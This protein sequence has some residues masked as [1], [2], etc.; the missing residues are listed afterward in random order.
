MTP[1]RILVVDD[2]EVNLYVLRSLLEG[3]GYTVDTARHGAEALVKA[4]AAPP[5]LAISD[6]LMPVMDG[7]TLLRHWKAD[8]R[9]R[10]IPF[11]V[12]TATYTEPADEKLALDLGADAFILKPA[13]PDTFV[14]R[15]REVLA[16]EQR[17]ELPP[18]HAPAAEERIVLREYNE[19]LVHKLEDKALQLEQANSALMQDIAARERAEAA[20]RESEQH[21]RLLFDNSPIGLALCRMDG[22]LVYVN[23]AY[24]RILGRTPEETLHLSYWD[25]TPPQ[26]A[27]Q[28][29]AQLR[30][31]R[32]TGR[33]GPYEKEYI[34]R[35]GHRVPV[36]LSGLLITQAGEQ[37]IWSS[38]EEITE[39][40]RAE[41]AL[42]RSNRALRILTECNEIMMRAGT[43]AELCQGVC[44]LLVGPGRFVMA[45]V[46]FAQEDD[47]KS[48]RP[49]A[50]SGFEAGYLDSL[51]ITWADQERG[52]G[53]SG[54]AIRTGA[55]SIARDIATDPAYGPWRAAAIQR[56]YASS[57]S[58]P[59][60]VSNQVVGA[61]SIYSAE[62]NAFDGGE[63]ELMT[64]LADDLAFGIQALRTRAKRQQAEEET[65]LR[66][67]ELAILSDLVGATA[68][69]LD[70]PT[71]LDRALR[72]ALELT[73]LEGGTLC[74]VHRDG[75]HLDLAAQI[76]TS[77]E[78]IRDLTT[79]AVRIGD[80]LCGECAR[81]CRPL[82]LWDNASG[83]EYATRESAR[84]EGI[85]FH[86]A[87][88]LPVHD[89]TIGVLCIFSRGDLQPSERR[90]KLVESLCGPVALAIENAR[91]FE[92]T[93]RELAARRQA[94]ALLSGQKRVL[95]LI[96]TGASLPESLTALVQLIESHA[97]GMLGSV[98]LLDDDGVHVR[99]G[100]APSL[101][102][103]FVAAVDGQPIGPV[104][105][106]CGT[107]AFRKEAVFVEDIATDPLWA[108][109]KAAALPHGLRACW[110]TP[111]LDASGIVL[112]TFAMYYREP[113]LPQPEHLR[114]IDIATQTAAIAI[115]RHR[116]EA[117]LRAKTGE[118]DRYFNNSLDLLCIADI[119]GYFRR[120]NPEWERTL[121]YPLAELVGRRFL[122][123]V[124]PDDMAATLA[125][126]SALSSQQHVLDFVNRYRHK[127]GTYRWIE[128]RA[129]AEDSRLYAVARDITER[130]R[131]EEASRA[132]QQRLRELIDGLGPSMLVGLLAPDGTVIEANRPALAA[133]A[134]KPEDVLGKPVDET[135]WWAYSPDIQRQVREA[136]GRA[137]RGEASRYDVDVRVAD[138]QFIT[139]DFS[140]EP[141]RDNTGT[142]VYVVASASVITERRRAEA[143]LRES[144]AKFRAIIE[145]SP[146]AMT[147][148]DEHGNIVFLNRKFVETFGYT[149][150]DIPTLAEWRLRA[151]PDPAYREQVAASWHASVG[152]AHS[153]RVER[154]PLEYRVT[155]KDGTV[156]DIRFSMAPIGTSSLVVLYDITELKQA[157]E[158]LR[159]AEAKFAGAFYGSPAAFSITRI[160]DGMFL[161]V[162]ESFLRTFGYRRDEVVG[163]R[164]T[165][166]GIITPEQRARLIQ[167]QLESGGLTNEELTAV[168][169]SGA[170]VQLLF[171]SRPLEVDGEACHVTTLID[172]TDRKLAEE[173]LL[174]ANAQLQSLSGR[175]LEIQEAER[176]TLA[177][178][179]HDELGQ[180]LSAI[181]IN[182]QTLQRF[183]VPEP[184]QL[185]ACAAMVDEA[186]Q[187]TRS[188]SLNLRPPLLDDLGL[189][190]ALRW[191]ADQVG[192]R[193]GL[194]V[195]V[196]SD[197]PMGRLAAPVETACFR[198][199]QEALSNAVRHAQ[200][201]QAVI[202]IVHTTDRLQV[203]VRDDGVGFDEAA[204]RR[205][206]REGG[207]MGLMSMEERATL[208]GGGVAWNSAPGSGTEVRFW[209]PLSASLARDTE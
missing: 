183:P 73:G 45:W 128:W 190:P 119:D 116:A 197:R 109:Y 99:H 181:K 85:R 100:A 83:S 102:A 96:A 105:G 177:R 7:Y 71:V 56:G 8:E 180:S 123:F 127:D 89:R 142:V 133:A 32:E 155:C 95:E 204:A 3:H 16:Q 134:L 130:R 60:K 4:R 132:S 17:G 82:V 115:S 67:R 11:V 206:A 141:V 175:L 46:G 90:L 68:T 193:A 61:L 136:V 64:E 35:D 139:L 49:M 209:V 106:S 120:L 53:P 126:M 1:K 205:R 65:A 179:L 57:I 107:A 110:S 176:R 137:A 189:L 202:S 38:V 28:E 114:L 24:A 70:L 51:H 10:S 77:P 62:P 148:A 58:L 81:T 36:R 33:Y 101:P 34:H 43:E 208:A 93:N 144:E 19:V 192:Q 167:W 92:A 31:L 80:C 9:L 178:E 104:A 121:G 30:S 63:A 91:L 59:L 131:A 196:E 55:P 158:V 103:E 54:V 13:E 169:R 14:A 23:P 76:D 157:E 98:L 2:N 124:H 94:D 25:V 161:D 154:E 138:H 122:D 78:T 149:I 172:I 129:Y 88:P 6:L 170:T 151:Y 188:L 21:H 117:A 198:I 118:L 22:T 152:K 166:L 146:V 69:T 187:N 168:N 185:A 143:A 203:S 182:L 173:R 125:A 15:I 18:A 194:R 162:N 186:L 108:E 40:R 199:A 42:R 159:Q 5:R 156:R 74:L 201:K 153:N 44:D 47:A 41:D 39:R 84:G 150:A 145:A 72:G 160:A 207:S 164:S 195:A 112:G 165:E 171:S 86:A 20:L 200:A 66:N 79:S 191:L 184:E 12:Y 26:Y 174:A 52:R 48:V 147:V 111:I 140:L 29:E 27:E 50:Q 163:H 37:F 87:F 75:E 113:S 135:Y 97:P